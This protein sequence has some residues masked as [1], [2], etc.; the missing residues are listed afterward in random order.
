MEY[1]NRQAGALEQERSLL[2]QEVQKIAKRQEEQPPLAYWQIWERLPVAEKHAVC[3][4]MLE[5]ILVS[6]QKLSFYWR[7]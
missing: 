1:I 6:P 5:H 2:L 3:D 7:F 4:A